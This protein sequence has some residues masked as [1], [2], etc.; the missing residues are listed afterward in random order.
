LI[1]IDTEFRCKNAIER[2]ILSFG[3]SIAMR[4][5]QP[6]DTMRDEQPHWDDRKSEYEL[7]QEEEAR[8][9][10]VEEYWQYEESVEHAIESLVANQP[11]YRLSNRIIELKNA[12]RDP[13]KER[14]AVDNLIDLI[15]EEIL[16]LVEV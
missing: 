9:A 12:A 8:E 3:R 13:E 4:D 1:K 5:E 10:Q 16:K 14:V 6:F 2:T 15:H 11:F 7:D